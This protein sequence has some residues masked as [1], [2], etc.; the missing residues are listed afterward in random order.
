MNSYAQILIGD[1]NGNENYYKK[2]KSSYSDAQI[3]Y[4]MSKEIIP[5]I[6]ERMQ[7]FMRNQKDLIDYNF[8][9]FQKDNGEIGFKNK[10]GDVV[11]RPKFDV[12][13][14]FYINDKNNLKI[15]IV[16]KKD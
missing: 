8:I 15:T 11:I 10:E 14:N 16:R 7:V 5:N 6:S 2:L 1:A 12:A 4:L 13:N 3:K 9:Q